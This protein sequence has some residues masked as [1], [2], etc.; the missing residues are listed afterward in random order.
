MTCAA[1]Q[2]NPQAIQSLLQ[3][4]FKSPL[5][6]DE[7]PAV[8]GLPDPFERFKIEYKSMPR[9]L[10]DVFLVNILIVLYYICLL[11]EAP[12][13]LGLPDPFNQFDF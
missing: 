6:L 1:A 4:Y 9:L 12:A 11:D 8:L 10:P 7:A 3:L 2:M 13:V 5:R